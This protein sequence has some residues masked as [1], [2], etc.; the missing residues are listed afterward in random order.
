MHP[1]IGSQPGRPCATVQTMLQPRQLLTSLPEFL[2]P[3]TP[4]QM[5]ISGAP[6]QSAAPSTD[7]PLQS[8][9]TP[10]QRSLEPGW[11]SLLS[12]P[13]VLAARSW[14]SPHWSG[15]LVLGLT[16]VMTPQL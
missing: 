13:P 16:A 12:T 10:L 5:A 15:M 8:S 7:P 2:Q 6:G 1:F 14:Q 3:N 9:S 4:Q 11:I